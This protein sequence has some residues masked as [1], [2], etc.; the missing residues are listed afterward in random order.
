M[1]DERSVG[2]VVFYMEDNSEPE[3][4]LLHYSAAT[5]TFQR[6]TLKLEKTKSRP[7]L[8]KFEETHY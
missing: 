4:L 2:A 5:G 7:L 1:I 6:V 8:V 3:Y